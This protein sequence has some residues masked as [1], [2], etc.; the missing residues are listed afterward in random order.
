MHYIIV[1]FMHLHEL[2]E[3][4]FSSCFVITVRAI[5]ATRILCASN[6]KALWKQGKIQVQDQDL[7]YL[8]FNPFMQ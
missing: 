5:H 8:C 2:H 4:S 1:H 6:F 7:L 3:Q